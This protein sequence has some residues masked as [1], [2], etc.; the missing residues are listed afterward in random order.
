MITQDSDDN[1]FVDCAIIANADYIVSEDAHFK[2]LE[3]ILFPKMNVI[4]LDSFMK[5]L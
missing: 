3:T 1:K 2:V 5:E 4:T